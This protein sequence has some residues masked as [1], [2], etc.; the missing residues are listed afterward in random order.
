MAQGEEEG[1]EFYLRNTISYEWG[2]GKGLSIYRVSRYTEWQLAGNNFNVGS[3]GK[4]WNI[5]HTIFSKYR[6]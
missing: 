6:K 2:G 1:E 3:D 5:R 4:T